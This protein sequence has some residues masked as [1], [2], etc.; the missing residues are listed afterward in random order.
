MVRLLVVYNT[1]FHEEVPF[2]GKRDRY[3][4][5][6]S[7]SLPTCEIL[8]IERAL[9]FPRKNADALESWLEL[10]L[11]VCLSATGFG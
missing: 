9:C 2:S 5:T 6:R 7:E 3:T 8:R 1:L 10:K 4:G 11:S